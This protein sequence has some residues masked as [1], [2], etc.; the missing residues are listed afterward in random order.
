MKIYYKAHDT[1]YGFGD[2][3]CKAATRGHA[4]ATA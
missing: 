1:L 3:T 2:M 4:T